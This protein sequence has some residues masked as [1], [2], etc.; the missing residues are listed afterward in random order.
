MDKGVLLV[1][2]GPSGVG[3]GTIKEIIKKRYNIIESVSAT[4]RKQRE[5]EI[6]GV[7]YFFMTDEQFEKKKKNNEFLECFDNFGKK[8]GTVRR[9]VEEGLSKHDV[10]IEIDVKGALKVKEQM[11]EAV[12]I[13]IVPPKISELKKR[14]EKR[15]TETQD[16][17]EKRFSIAK[18][19]LSCYAEYDYIVVNDD[20]EIA[21]EKIAKIIETEKMK[22]GNQTVYMKNMLLT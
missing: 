22:S 18:Q 3:K 20:L 15:N 2:S 6:E 13:L 5:G 8:Y 7:S 4:T 16:Q 14:L 12:L 10:L 17:I 9:Y 19:E 11:K 1:L 21:V